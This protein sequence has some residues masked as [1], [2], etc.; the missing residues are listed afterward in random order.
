MI[1]H[2]L[3]SHCASLRAASSAFRFHPAAWSLPLQRT[4][5][6]PHYHQQKRHACSKTN[7]KSTTAPC[8]SKAAPKMT[9]TAFW[10]ASP[11]WRRAAVNTTRCLVGCTTG[12]F[13]TMWFLQSQFPDLSMGITMSAASK[14]TKKVWRL[15]IYFHLLYPVLALL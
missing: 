13:S 15:Y 3:P 7:T 8:G 12:D 11:T 6:Q 14:S 4:Q 2:T 10:A 1:R 5:Q 9:S